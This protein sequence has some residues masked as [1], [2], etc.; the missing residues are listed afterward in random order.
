[1][2]ALVDADIPSA[3]ARDSE[4][5][6]GYQP[7]DATLTAVAGASTGAD[8]MVY[9]SAADTAAVTTFTAWG[10]GIVDDTDQTAARITLGLVPGTDVQAYDADLAAYAALGT[11]GLVA[12]TGAGTVT[13]RTITGDSEIVVSNGDGVSGNP[14]LAIASAIA[15]DAEVA[16]AY[17]PLDTDLTALAAGTVMATAITNGVSVGSPTQYVGSTNVAQH[18]ALKA[19]IDSPTF[20]SDPK[21]PTPTAGDNDTSIATTAY[22]QGEIS[23]LSS[24]SDPFADF[25]SWETRTWAFS[26]NSTTLA[27]EPGLTFTAIASGTGQLSSGKT[28]FDGRSAVSVRSQA[29]SAVTSTGGFYTDGGTTLFLSAQP[30]QMKMDIALNRTNGSAYRFGLGDSTTTTE[31]TDALGFF[32]T[33]DIVCGVTLSNSIKAITSTYQLQQ[34][35]SY[36]LLLLQT[37][38][39]ARFVISSNIAGAASVSVYDQ[40]VVGIPLGSARTL[41]IQFGGW[42]TNTANTNGIDYLFVDSMFARKAK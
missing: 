6:A 8:V 14:T 16:A 34:G 9:F 38:D 12:R 20:T 22:V 24:G 13:A 11:A 19:P 15:R 7:L 41:S 10:R 30:Y 1:M 40:S 23:G 36:R 25:D 26:G 21:A 35:V 42:N 2:R 29:G 37:N 31:P 5:A 28:E 33:N 39:Y 17:Q 4:V 32:V 18:L 3:I 27:I